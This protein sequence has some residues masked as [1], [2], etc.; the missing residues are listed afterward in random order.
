MNA[1]HKSLS[2]TFV[3]FV[4]DPKHGFGMD[5]GVGGVLDVEE[6]DGVEDVE[7]VEDA[8]DVESLSCSFFENSE[9]NP[10]T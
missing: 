2:N 10:K 1:K 8:E 6:V 4:T 9:E 7:G 5:V 3:D